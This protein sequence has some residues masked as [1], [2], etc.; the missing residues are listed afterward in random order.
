MKTIGRLII[1]FVLFSVPAFSQ[2]KD[3]TIFAGVQVP[4]KITLSNAPSSGSSG[5]TQIIT[6]PKNASEFGIRFGHGK[7][8]GGEHSLSYAPDFLD[9]QSK[10]I[11][12][13]SNFRIQAPFPVIRPY[14]TAGLGTILS[15]GSGVSDLGTKFAVNYGGG[16][17]IM[18]GKVGVNIGLR[19]YAVPS[20]QS[21]TLYI[22][23]ASVGVNFGF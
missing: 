22:T 2:G 21:Q 23:E 14:A 15:W 7:V 1:A 16:V 17:K 10:A 4:Q 6:N 8:F 11:L 9:S 5:V 20:V 19:G 12:Y 18:P 3:F 13:S